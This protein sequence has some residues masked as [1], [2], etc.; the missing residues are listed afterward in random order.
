MPDARPAHRPDAA[1]RRLLAAPGALA[2]GLLSPARAYATAH[3]AFWFALVAD[4]PYSALEMQSHIRVLESIGPE[5]EFL[6]HLGDLKNGIEP[7]HD[8]LYAERRRMFEQHSRVPVIFVPGDNDWADCNRPTA[9]GHDPFERL[10]RLR[11]TFFAQPRSLGPNAF[12][13]ERQAGSAAG[14][15]YPENLRWRHRDTM[16]VTLN[17]P[18]GIQLDRLPRLQAAAMHELAAAN[19]RWLREAFALAVRQKL[20]RLVI[21]AHADP[22]WPLDGDSLLNLVRTDLHHGFRQLLREL[23]A[24]FDGPVLFLHGDTHVF[25]SDLPLRDLRGG[26]VGNLHRV[27]AFGAPFASSWVQL[28][29]SPDNDPPYLVS[30]RELP[31]AAQNRP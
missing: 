29:V 7:C 9:G 3:G 15:A 31:P 12:A 16:M 10:G 13:V 27:E 21:A 25:R 26:R 5:C 17:R 2:A 20:N 1:R 22:D 4:E 28:R 8:A 23:C 24:S 30:T 14:G 11:E 18:G 19:E 6:I